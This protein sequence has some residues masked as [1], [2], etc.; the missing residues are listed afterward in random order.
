MGMTSEAR[1]TVYGEFAANF[2]E[3]CLAKLCDPS[4][5][6]QTGPFGSQL[7]QQD[8]VPVGTPIITVEHLG[9]NRIIH[10]D[11]P[12]V[13]DED[14][15]RLSKYIL[16][17]GDI[18]FSRVGSVDRRSLVRDAENGWLFS[19]R[20]LRVRPDPDKI[21]PV[22]LS[23]FFGLPSFKEHIRAIAVGATMPSL[24]TE[25]LSNVIVPYPQDLNEQRAIARILGSLDDKIEANR[26]MNETLEA[27]ARAIFKSWFVDFDPMRAK[28]E[29]REPAGMDAETAALF[30][31]SFEETERGMVPK[32]WK[33][34]NLGALLAVIETGSRPKGGV[35]NITGG[36][37]SIGAE[38]I[39]G[40]GRFDYAKTKFIP[41]E[42]YSSM[43]R[44]HVSDYDILLYKD[45]GR[46]GEFEPHISLFGNGFPFDRFCINEHVYRLRAKPNL[47][48]SYLYFWLSSNSVM[49]EMRNRGTG[50]AVP[51][52]NSTAVRGLQVLVPPNEILM[53][54]DRFAMHVIQLILSNSNESRYLSYIRDG[55]LPRLLS[56]DICLNDLKFIKGDHNAS[57]T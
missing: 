26:C 28:A 5:G 41:L 7:H 4:G 32:R 19:G 50:V 6:I 2:V 31:D 23:Y 38:S 37:P 53:K 34:N 55:L 56:G 46:P 30:P 9:E 25:I 8:Y 52:L 11:I 24:N 27:I 18:V 35:G 36:V 43:K 40:L 48:Q 12:C 21:D 13:S 44:G 33:A 45:G 14:K 42:Y 10:Q 29:G 39:E 17:K 3:D 20:C 47:P 54:F 1:V 22:Y 15:E 51:G 57:N 49:E 16:R